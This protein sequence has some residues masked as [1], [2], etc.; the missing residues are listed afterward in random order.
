M[1]KW[2]LW[3][4]SGIFCVQ[5]AFCQQTASGRCGEKA[6]Q[7]SLQ[8][9]FMDKAWKEYGAYNNPK[10]QI[11]YDSLIALCP[12]MANAYRE[13][14]IPYIKNGEYA[15]AM[16][17]EDKAVMLDPKAFTAYRGF[18]K[19]IFTKDYEGALVDFEQAEKLSPGGFEMDHTYP[20]YQGLCYL[21][22]KDYPQAEKQFKKDVQ[23]Q[24]GNDKQ[25]KSHHLTSLY[26]GILY[27]EMKKYTEAE[28]YLKSAITAYS[29]FSDAHFY[30]GLVY[31]KT[32]RKSLATSHLQQA[33][34]AVKQGYGINEDNVIYAYYP[35]QITA[36]EVEQALKAD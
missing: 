27:L 8:V 32:A 1:E 25:R 3:L 22:L 7:D 11:Y 23:I 12:N 15:K 30:L 6:F 18:L 28:K 35:Y 26:L 19:C 14:A 20:F 17:L 13:K 29:Q 34:S 9:H 21:M 10:W 5:E 36:Y 2:W 31:K 24:I 4:L 33:L 16:P